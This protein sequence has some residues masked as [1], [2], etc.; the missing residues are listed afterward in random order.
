M[1]IQQ[2]IHKLKKLNTQVLS[3]P[4]SF[5]YYPTDSTISVIKE[6][7]FVNGLSTSGKSRNYRSNWVVSR[8]K[9]GRQ[10]AFVDLFY[11]GDG[12]PLPGSRPPSLYSTFKAKKQGDVSYMLVDNDHNFS[13]KLKKEEGERGDILQPN[14][15]EID[16]LTKLVE[17]SIDVLI[18][19][20]LA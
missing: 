15:S 3:K 4:T 6:R 10:T 17:F 1:T 12:K 7:V 9:A 19:K 13:V 8:K 14:D 18:D 5:T 20:S 2:A 11:Q 16:Y